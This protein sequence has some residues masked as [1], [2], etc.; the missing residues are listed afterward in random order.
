MRHD[1][2]PYDIQ[3][4]ND[5]SIRCTYCGNEFFISTKEI[6]REDDPENASMGIR[7]NHRFYSYCTCSKCGQDISIEQEVSEYP[8][9]NIEYAFHPKCSGGQ[10]LI[11]PKVESTYYGD[12]PH[13][14]DNP[15]YSRHLISKS[16][17]LNMDC[18]LNT[19][20]VEGDAH[21]NDPQYLSNKNS[22][23]WL[24]PA[25]K[26]FPILV[27]ET[28]TIRFDENRA[29]FAEILQ[30]NP[31]IRVMQLLGKVAEAVMVRNCFDDA[32]LNR[33]WLA[34]ARKNRTLQRVADS[35]HAIGTGLHSTKNRYPQKY[36]PSD[37]QRDIIWINEDGECALVA[38]AQTTV[39]VVAGLQVKVSGNGLSY[40]QKDLINQRYEVPLVYF[41]L[42]NDFDRIL[43]KINGSRMVVEPGVD[44]I[45]VRELD[46]NAFFEIKAYYPLLKA[47]F[48][49][50][51]SCDDFIKEAS[52]LDPLKN[53]ILATTLP[54]SKFDIRIIH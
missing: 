42:N 25:R 53:S 15:M 11:A 52:G 35:F 28:G 36:N 7:I 31:K 14:S 26:L 54:S 12:E 37:P 8:K 43:D 22:T 45:D 13:V 34:K 33:A 46:A 10:I 48:I 27:E 21:I 2:E 40:I 44:F 38:G 23:I 32:Q 50:Q 49:G 20:I 19:D 41:P 39:G 24:N 17:V 47:L 16:S 29:V 5:V 3:I 1:F 9:G 18:R 6:E 4:T 51:M 30:T